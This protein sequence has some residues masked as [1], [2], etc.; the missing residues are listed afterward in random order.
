MKVYVF[1]YFLTGT[2]NGNSIVVHTSVPYGLKQLDENIE[3]VESSI[4]SNL[5]K[6][7]PFLPDPTST[8]CQRWRFSQVYKPFE[9]SPGC[10]VLNESPLIIAGGDSFSSSNFDGCIESSTS[11]FNCL[12][13]HIKAK[14]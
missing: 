2:D 13:N 4:R 6:L 9:G 8:K 1:S 7:L 12:S 10:I 5:K 3:N 14:L 11:I